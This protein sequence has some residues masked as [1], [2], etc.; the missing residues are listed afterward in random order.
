MSSY[1]YSIRING[2][3]DEKCFRCNKEKNNLSKRK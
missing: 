1:N 3:K 2:G